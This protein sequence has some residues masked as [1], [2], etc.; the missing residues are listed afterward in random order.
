MSTLKITFTTIE[1]NPDPIWGY[2]QFQLT[3]DGVVHQV[4]ETLT[5]GF[6][7]FGKFAYSG[8][9]PAN[10][11]QSNRFQAQEYLAS[12]QR[13]HLNVGGQKNL[14]IGIADNVITIHAV[15]GV[16]SNFVY[17]GDM[18]S[19]SRT[20]END[21]P[22]IPK[23]FEYTFDGTGDCTNVD[24]TAES[25]TGGTAPYRLTAGGVD[26]F[27]GW[28]GATPRA[29]QLERTKNY[30]GG[31]Y[32]SANVLIKS[33][34][35][36]PPKK[37]APSDFNVVSTY[38]P[39]A[40]YADVT[41]QTVVNRP[42]TGPLQYSL[43]DTWQSSNIF[44]GVLAGVYTLKIRDKFGCELEKT[45]EVYQVGGEDPGTPEEPVRRE[46]YFKISEFNS[47]SFYRADRH[48]PDVRKNYLNTGSFAEA[49]GI[50]KTARF[51]FPETSSIGTKFN[52]SYPYHNVTLHKWDGSKQAIQ[53]F[54]I[55]ENLG[56]IERVDCKVFPVQEVLNTLE[57]GTVVIND[58][59]GVYFDGGNK[60]E[61]NSSTI[62]EDSPY[63]SGLPSWAVKGAIINFAGLG[64]KEIT[65]T[66]LFDELRGV[67][68]FKIAGTVSEGS[69]IVQAT[70]DR[71]PYNVFRFDFNME[72]VHKEGNYI[73]IEPGWSFDDIDRRFVHKSEPFL[74][75]QDLAKYLKVTWGAF[76][77]LGEMIFVDNMKSEM[78]IKGKIRPFPSGSSEFEDG[79]DSTRSIDQ[80]S[81]LRMRAT[82]PIMTP[83]QWRKFDLIGTIGSRGEVY[84][85]DMKLVRI[86]AM[87]HD[88]LG[89]TN[90]S[91]ISCD[92]AFSGESSKEGQLDPVIDISTGETGTGGSG[93][94]PVVGWQ[95]EGM[96]LMT[97]NGHWIKIDGNFVEVSE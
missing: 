37:L 78:W 69:E 96:R 2:I 91:N 79:D 43:A 60:Y 73:K 80:E 84:I 94:E 53:F 92:F 9:H 34:S 18:I 40:G 13:D 81:Y 58:G 41:V 56:A 12:F 77:N 62:I 35:E 64:E 74:I 36:I 5:D 68:Y 55:Q 3:I 63:T 29:F 28:A 11:A 21:I 46:P 54:M 47:L 67:T 24:Y 89:D 48:G 87:D 39:S 6:A 10:Q 32:D 97:E 75:L 76:R 19:V 86:K 22:P 93:K 42:G 65:E 26:I 23:T 71:H 25:A 57:G 85:E 90:I 16:F 30:S 27:T 31:L 1:P 44:G 95:I 8:H 15:K 52:S 14:G 72:D 70:F 49:V 50:P 66:N 51:G 82:I 38:N 59:S 4:R 20:I 88:E 45:F 33:F 7:D 17:G 61:P 83:K